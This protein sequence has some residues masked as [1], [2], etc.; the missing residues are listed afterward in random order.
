MDRDTVEYIALREAIKN[1]VGDVL[2]IDA[3]AHEVLETM[4]RYISN[5][6]R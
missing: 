5:S 6:M 2:W 1:I 3:L 4:H